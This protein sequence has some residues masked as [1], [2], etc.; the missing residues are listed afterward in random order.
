[1]SA[2][3]SALAAT[4]T[5]LR[6]AS[7]HWEAERGGAAAHALAEAAAAIRSAGF[8]GR[9]ACQELRLAVLAL[10]SQ[11][12]QVLWFAASASLLASDVA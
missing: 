9:E 4:A 8:P 6:R 2:G 5:R 3:L 1:M 12:D 7:D 11:S 10:N